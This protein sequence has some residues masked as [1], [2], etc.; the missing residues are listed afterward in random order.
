MQVFLVV[1]RLKKFSLLGIFQI[2]MILTFQKP[3]NQIMNVQEGVILKK[4]L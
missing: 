3:F 2:L 4:N 1:L